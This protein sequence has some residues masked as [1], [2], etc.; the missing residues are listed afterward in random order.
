M[1]DHDSSWPAHARRPLRQ[2]A[3]EGPRFRSMLPSR[4]PV[5]ATAQPCGRRGQVALRPRRQAGGGWYGPHSGLSLPAGGPHRDSPRPPDVPSG[6][7]SLGARECRISGPVG[8]RNPRHSPRSPGPMTVTVVE[9][10]RA[11]WFA[12]V[13]PGGPVEAGQQRRV[14]STLP[15]AR[16]ADIAVRPLSSLGP[17]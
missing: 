5:S 13:A 11:T 14:T 6:S 1:A 12:L 4:L 15:A 3:R 2:V 7:V 16:T 8:R 17:H 9:G 10:P